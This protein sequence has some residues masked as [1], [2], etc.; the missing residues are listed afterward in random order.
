MYDHQFIIC[1]PNNDHINLNNRKYASI[2]TNNGHEGTLT[3]L[4]YIDEIIYNFLNN[5]FNDNLLKD[6]SVILLS[7][8]GASMPSI[9]YL[10]DFYSIEINLPMLFILINDRKNISYEIQYNDINKNQQSLITGFDI[11]NTFGNL[12]FGDEY[13]Y[14]KNKSS[15]IETPKSEYGISLFEKINSGQIFIMIGFI[16]LIWIIKC[17]LFFIFIILKF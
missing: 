14:F 1:D 12:A 10:F 16:L 8:H 5:L 3:V 15:L 4:K 2:I 7:D 13:F 17:F 11:Y 6:S 9:Y